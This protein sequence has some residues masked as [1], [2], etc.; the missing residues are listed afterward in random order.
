MPRPTPAQRAAG[1]RLAWA[2]VAAL[3]LLAL[4]AGLAEMPDPS[5]WQARADRWLPEASAVRRLE[6]TF[7]PGRDGLAG[8]DILVNQ[9]AL[10]PG[11]ALTVRLTAEADGREVASVP[12]APGDPPGPAV[13]RLRFEP[14]PASAG[15]PYRLVA[16]AGGEALPPGLVAAAGDDPYPEGRLA[17]DGVPIPGS[18]RF[19]AYYRPDPGRLLGAAAGA[20]RDIPAVALGVGLWL[21]PGLAISALLGWPQAPGLLGRAAAGGS[22]S[23]AY[24]PLVYYWAG[25]LGLPAF[26]AGLGLG[27]GLAGA[28]V[29]RPGRSFRP[30]QAVPDPAGGLLLGAVLGLTLLVRLYPLGDL[31][32]TPWV[33][34]PHHALIARKVLE[35]NR[36]PDSYGPEVETPAF[37]HFGFHVQ[38]ALL[39]RTTGADPAEA[40]GLA[41]QLLTAWSAVLACWLVREWTADPRAGLVGAGLA[42]LM[43]T[44]P[45]YLLSWSRFS[46]AAGLDL[47]PAVFL[48]GRAWFRSDRAAGALGI[49]LAGLA[50]THYRLLAM[51]GLFLLLFAAFSRKD[52]GPW[53]RLGVRLGLTLGT[54]A[55]ALPWLFLAAGRFLFPAV[56]TAVEAGLNSDPFPWDL[57][58]R[59]PDGPVFL[60]AVG[61]LLAGLRRARPDALALGLTLLGLG[62]LAGALPIPSPLPNVIDGVTLAASLWLGA[63]VPAAAAATRLLD[64]AWPGNGA[65]LGAVGALVLVV[66][67]SQVGRQLAAVNPELVLVHPADLPALAWVRGN[68]PRDAG[69]LING[70]EWRPGFYAGADAGFWLPAA[71]GRTTLLPTLLYGNLPAEEFAQRNRIAREL[72]AGP[73]DWGRLIPELRSLKIDYVFIGRRGGPL[74]AGKLLGRPEFEAVYHRAG[75]WVFRLRPLNA[76]GAPKKPCP[77]G[78]ALR[79]SG[80]HR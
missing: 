33:D 9:A 19:R 16:E 56:R 26:E 8:V 29:V 48:A 77:G 22:F 76:A 39:A 46:L 17:A 50:L 54:F 36:V 31:A 38:A 70:F 74:T 44:F 57:V 42:G 47:L 80:A 43:L 30:A 23:L 40:V 73:V 41:G 10:K 34:G 61:G 78:V 15:R 60:L 52:A 62:F 11:Q 53:P 59:W 20:F 24:W 45:G 69:F 32:L 18:L 68:T 71:A 55:S 75:V 1:R 14:Q 49:L 7:T 65:G 3:G 13:V 64:R 58:V 72:A 79:R 2:G 37:Y 66:C 4:W 51:G 63:L 6:Q 28:A 35:A 25:R 27:V 67:C 5:A 12:V 21:L